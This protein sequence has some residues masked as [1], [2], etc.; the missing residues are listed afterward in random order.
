MMHKE[1]S[2]EIVH[3]VDKLMGLLDSLFARKKNIKAH[4]NKEVSGKCQELLR[5]K[6]YLDRIADAEHYISRKELIAENAQYSETMKFFLSLDE[7]DILED[8][9][10]KNGFDSDSARD[11][12]HQYEHI[13]EIVAKANDAYVASKLIK[14]KDYLDNILRNVDPAVSLDE[15]Q[16]KVVLS[17]EDY[18]LVVAGAGAGKTTTVAAKVKYLVDKQGINPE[19]ILIISFTIK[20]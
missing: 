4:V 11:L 7:N 5:W 1:A 6:Q 3:K 14:E 9:C 10:L 20:L 8:Y 13:E 18:S 12:C 17:D 15:D 16:R 19:Q 2:I